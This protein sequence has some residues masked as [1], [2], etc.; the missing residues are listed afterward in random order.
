VI[1]KP[2]LHLPRDE[3][4]AI[5]V[6]LVEDPGSL[7][8]FPTLLAFDICTFKGGKLVP[9]LSSY[10]SHSAD[11]ELIRQLG[12]IITSVSPDR[13]AQLY[14]FTSD[15]ITAL[16]QIV[17][18]QFL[19]DGDSQ[20]IRTCLGVVVDL[21]LSLLTGIQP[22]LL[23]NAL[24][25]NWGKAKRDQLEQHLSDLRLDTSGSTPEMQDRLKEALT[26][27]TP[28]LGRLPKVVCVHRSLSE[29]LAF[30]GPGYITLGDCV[31]HILGPCSLPTDDEL[32]S[33]AQSNSPDLQVKVRARGMSIYRIIGGVRARLR[34]HLGDKSLDTILVNDA[35][36]LKPLYLDLC[37]DDTLRKLSFMHEVGPI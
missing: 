33:L 35:R 9:S 13:T 30:P 10:S 4:Y 28:A 29:L 21:P 24:Y 25:S 19:T 11:S 7:S 2:T 22:E 16:N 14:C 31:R 34:L 37:H 23:N 6:S 17:I 36:P 3:N 32:F 1:G 8:S 15:E 5:I 26:A 12:R 27:E 18:H 20:D